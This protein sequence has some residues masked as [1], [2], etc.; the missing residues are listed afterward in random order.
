M[1]AFHW[2]RNIFDGQDVV[3]LGGLE[4]LVSV[5]LLLSFFWLTVS[6]FHGMMSSQFHSVPMS[7]RLDAVNRSPLFCCQDPSV[8]TAISFCPLDDVF[9]PKGHQASL[10][11]RPCSEF[12]EKL[13]SLQSIMKIVPMPMQQLR[14]LKVFRFENVSGRRNSVGF[15]FF[16]VLLKFSVSLRGRMRR[17]IS[18]IRDFFCNPKILLPK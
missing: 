7:K 16:P 17:I 11:L 10:S 5:F 3:A 6:S 8:S 4:P 15:F 12:R 2:T 9:P 14:L 1:Q 13:A 18:F